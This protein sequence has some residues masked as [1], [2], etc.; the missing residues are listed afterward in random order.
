[1]NFCYLDEAGCTGMLPSAAA[2]IQPVFI[3]GGVVFPG[4]DLHQWTREFID[5]KKRFFPSL[6]PSPMRSLDWILPEIKGSELR[7]FLRLGSHR[8]TRHALGCIGHALSI[9]ERHD[10][11]LLGRIYIKGIGAQFDGKAVY[12]ASTQSICLHLQSLLLQRQETGMVIADSRNK[13]MNALVSHSVFTQKIRSVGDP[14]SRLSELPVFG[15][16]ENHAGLQIAD[17]ICSA[18]LFP[19]ACHVYCTGYVQNLHVDSSY[20]ILAARFSQRLRKLQYRYQDSSGRWVGG[21]SVIDGHARRSGSL[22]FR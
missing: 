16:S 12:A 13:P 3:L 5:L 8:K 6:S 1:M 14:F 20:R 15:H 19:M 17:V 2:P 7:R 9:V 11:K 10:G 21:I 4:A 18:L 22:L